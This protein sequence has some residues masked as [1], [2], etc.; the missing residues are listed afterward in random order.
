MFT[1]HGVSASPFVRKVLV[2]LHE[3][4]LPFENIPVIPGSGGEL[5][6]RHSPLGKVPLLQDGDFFVPDSS[7]ISAYLE[8]T[9]PT[10]ALFPENPQ[11]YAHALWLEEYADTRLAM[12]AGTVF[13]ERFLAQPIFNRPPDEEKVRAVLA[14][15]VPV[16]NA[17]L[18]EQLS[19]D[20][21][22]GE[23]FGI[24]DISV[25]V[26]YVG[27]VYAREPVDA[28]QYPKLAAFLNTTLARP[29]FAAAM[30]LDKKALPGT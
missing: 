18:E 20:F 23:R 10:P 15:D 14:K 30:A 22:A 19:G 2:V 1:V 29:S 21:F 13:F 6:N 8:K 26:H 4:N 11:D 5:F 17:Y 3:K 28:G 7:V 16:V 9:H 27:L 24:A 25:A 12:A